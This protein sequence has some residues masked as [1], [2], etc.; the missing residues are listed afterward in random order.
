MKHRPFEREV[1]VWSSA[2][3]CSENGL[4]GQICHRHAGVWLEMEDSLQPVCE[5]GNSVIEVEPGVSTL[6]WVEKAT[7]PGL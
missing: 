4:W 1:F 5:P 7:Q 2:A 3:V 6:V